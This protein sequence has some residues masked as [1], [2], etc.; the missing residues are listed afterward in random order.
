MPLEWLKKR[1]SILLFLF[2]FL[3]T[4]EYIPG[5]HFSEEN[6]PNLNKFAKMMSELPQLQKYRDYCK[7]LEQK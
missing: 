2:W 1:L 7:K 3:G 5:E 6:Y 4:V